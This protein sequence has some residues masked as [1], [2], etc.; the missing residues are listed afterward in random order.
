MKPRMTRRRRRR[1][2]L[3]HIKSFKVAVDTRRRRRRKV[4]V[5]TKSGRR[6]SGQNTKLSL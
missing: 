6:G 2:R 3:W 5:D 1:K 4:A